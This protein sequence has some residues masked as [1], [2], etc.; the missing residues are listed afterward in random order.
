[1]APGSVSGA[2]KA[3]VEE[4][5]AF[6]LVFPFEVERNCFWNLN[7]CCLGI[8]FCFRQEVY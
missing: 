1:M 5:V 2:E 4:F 3:S 8:D 6:S 7:Y